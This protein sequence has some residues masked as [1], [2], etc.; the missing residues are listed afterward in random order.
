MVFG[1]GLVVAD[2]AAVFGDPPEGPRYDPPAVPCQW[3]IP[4][5]PP[6]CPRRRIPDPAALYI[7]ETCRLTKLV[8]TWITSF[9]VHMTSHIALLDTSRA[10]A[11]EL[12]RRTTI[13]VAVLANDPFVLSGLVTMLRGTAGIELVTEAAAADVTV[14]VADAGMHDMLTSDITRLVIIADELRQ[15]ELWTAIDHESVVVVPREE[16]TVQVRLQRAISNAR[17]GTGQLPTDQ[18][19]AV[20]RSLEHQQQ[21]TPHP[22]NLS[23]REAHVIRLLANGLDTSE[24]AMQLIYSERTVKNVLH[25]LLSR[26]NLRNR[27]HAVSYALRHG[28]I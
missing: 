27:V 6:G 2:A 21:R 13:R 12:A 1:Q 3:P 24:I 25:N 17:E 7:L 23:P 9:P 4:T 20:L 16:A 11:V 22:S 8:I 14:A 26:L 18:L 28:L 5:R 10:T 19:R 15:T